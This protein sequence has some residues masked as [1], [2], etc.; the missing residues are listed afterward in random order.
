MQRAATISD[1]ARAVV[2]TPAIARHRAARGPGPARCRGNSSASYRA[3]HV[4]SPR[5]RRA[6]PRGSRTGS[7]PASLALA[8]VDAPPQELAVERLAIEAEDLRGIRAVA[9]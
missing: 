2:A 9:V 6:W 8:V 1:R 4:R 5:H 3:G 7:S